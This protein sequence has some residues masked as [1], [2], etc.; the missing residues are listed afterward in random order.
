MIFEYFINK[1]S[2][3]FIKVC[4]H[5]FENNQNNKFRAE[6]GFIYI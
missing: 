4:K 6:L 5:F 2:A 1:Y 3:N